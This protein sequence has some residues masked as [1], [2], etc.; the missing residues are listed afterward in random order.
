MESTSSFSSKLP[1]S[2]PTPDFLALEFKRAVESAHAEDD[3][4][5]ALRRWATQSRGLRTD[6]AAR[7]GTEGWSSIAK[8]GWSKPFWAAA[9]LHAQLLERGSL[10]HA[11]FAGLT[12]D[13]ASTIDYFAPARQ[14]ALE[15]AL[16]IAALAGQPELCEEAIKKGARGVKDPSFTAGGDP[17][18][19]LI[20]RSRRDGQLRFGEQRLE[21]CA[22]AL[23][24]TASLDFRLGQRQM[25]HLGLAITAEMPFATL[26]AMSIARPEWLATEA[27]LGVPVF[28]AACEKGREAFARWLAEKMEPQGLLA[29][30]RATI[31]APA[32]Q[33]QPGER[34]APR[35]WLREWAAQEEAAQIAAELAKDDR[36]GDTTG[37]TRRA[38]KAL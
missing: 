24:K 15:R 16:T 37:G 22:S 26:K 6:V 5:A 12:D 35:E 7:L 1:A 3:A 34:S 33:L 17:L 28:E 25:T 4:L 36:Q 8:R 30:L 10:D 13:S 27:W 2:G 19:L 31:D 21:R 29:R 20:T 23:A 32:P 38:P 18:S 9:T 14:A 11:L